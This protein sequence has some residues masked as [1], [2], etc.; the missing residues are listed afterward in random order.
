MTNVIPLGQRRNDLQ[1]LVDAIKQVV[2]ERVGA[3]SVTEAIG[4]LEVAKH[5]IFKEQE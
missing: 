3:I 1:E 2:Y 4:A 5:E